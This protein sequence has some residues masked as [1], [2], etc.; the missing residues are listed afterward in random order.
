M[1]GILDFL[2]KSDILNIV[3]YIYYDKIDVDIIS[4]RVFI[5]LCIDVRRIYM[6]CLNLKKIMCDIIIY[7]KFVLIILIEK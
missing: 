4:N 2:S 3:D 1:K 7:I 5:M 6:V